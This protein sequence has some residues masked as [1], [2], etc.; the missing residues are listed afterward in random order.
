MARLFFAFEKILEKPANHAPIALR[1]N[2]RRNQNNFSYQMRCRPRYGHRHFNRFLVNL[3]KCAASRYHVTLDS[4][5]RSDVSDNEHQAVNVA[6]RAPLT[7]GRADTETFGVRS[8]ALPSRRLMLAL[9]W[10]LELRWDY[11]VCATQFM[12]LHEKMQP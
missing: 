3:G 2:A 11:S 12:T 7:R 1:H 10:P 8:I 4:R 9:D 5:E 6:S